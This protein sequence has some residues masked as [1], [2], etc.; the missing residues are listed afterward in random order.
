MN[1][2]QQKNINLNLNINNFT[3]KQLI[4]R[5]DKMYNMRLDKDEKVRKEYYVELGLIEH[6][7]AYYDEL[8]ELCKQF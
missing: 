7:L 2:V 5:R 6:K 4:Q 1:K 8:P 3:Y